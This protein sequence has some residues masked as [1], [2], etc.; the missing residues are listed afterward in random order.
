MRGI[1]AARTKPL[2]TI[3]AFESQNLTSVKQYELPK[4]K[5]GVKLISAENPEELI[6]LLHEEAKV[7]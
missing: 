7:I 5:A 6:K 3:P 1:M 4:E 2:A